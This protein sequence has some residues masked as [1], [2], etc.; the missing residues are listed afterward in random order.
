[1]RRW[2]KGSR[3]DFTQVKAKALGGAMH[4]IYFYG[5]SKKLIENPD[6]RFKTIAVTVLTKLHV[7]FP[8]KGQKCQNPIMVDVV[9]M[10]LK[11][12]YHAIILQIQDP[13]CSSKHQMCDMQANTCAIWECELVDLNVSLK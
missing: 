7:I 5:G 1:M 12:P 2:I 11:S 8:Q 3:P 6:M 10:S 13:L 4:N 9:S